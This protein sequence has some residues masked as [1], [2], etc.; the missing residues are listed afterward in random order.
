MANR[1]LIVVGVDGTDGGRRALRWAMDEARRTGGTVAAVTAWYWD[2]VDFDDVPVAGPAEQRTYAERISAREVNRVLAD[3]EP[4]LTGVPVARR[5]VQGHPVKVLTDASSGARLLV[6]GSHG[7]HRLHQA[8][9][10]SISESS[11]RHAACP[12]VVVPA[13][14]PVAAR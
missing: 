2:G 13:R 7:R 6:L 5:V 11:V 8:L 9:L 14:E 3:L 12:V 1:D 10:G 4:G